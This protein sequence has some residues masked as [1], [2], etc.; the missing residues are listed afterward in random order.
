MT[1]VVAEIFAHCG[2]R[3]WGQ[4]LH[5]CQIGRGRFHDDGVFERSEILERFHNL[6]DRRG[7]LP[8]RDVN[9]NY[10][11]AL[12]VYYCVDCNRS[13][14]SLSITDNQLALSAPNGHHRI[15]SLEPRLQWFLD[16]LPVDDTGSNTFNCVKFIR[17]DWTAIID[18][19]SQ[20]VDNATH[21]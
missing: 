2:A 10:V 1:A 9:A 18:R 11:F 3:I 17:N 16:W 13:F 7:L 15:D 12:L 5:G 19:V 20:G 4:E 14:S 6:R 8:D 21:H